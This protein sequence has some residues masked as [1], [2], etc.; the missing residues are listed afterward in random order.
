MLVSQDLIYFSSILEI[1][2]DFRNVTGYLAF[3]SELKKYI[4]IHPPS[5]TMRK[6][7]LKQYGNKYVIL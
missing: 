6:I 7:Q 2:D 1:L 5:P 3:N 4:Y